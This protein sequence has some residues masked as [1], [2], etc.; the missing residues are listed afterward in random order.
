[1]A[2]AVAKG[3][4]FSNDSKGFTFAKGETFDDARKVSPLE[5]VKPF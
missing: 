4:P 3:S 1:L 2:W 5:E